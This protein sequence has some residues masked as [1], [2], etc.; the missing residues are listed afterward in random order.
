MSDIANENMI[1]EKL[2]PL[3]GKVAI[4]DDDYSEVASL[5][6]F[7]SKNSIPYNYYDGK[8]YNFPENKSPIQLIFI[9]LGINGAVDAKTL[10]ATLVSNV[11]AL[12]GDNNG[13]YCLAIWSNNYIQNKE[14]VDK[15]I[16]SLTNKPEF[17]FDMDKSLLDTCGL[18][19]S[20]TDSSLWESLKNNLVDGY[21]KR[22]LVG[23]MN[24][25]SNIYSSE[26]RNIIAVL[27]NDI[28]QD[29][30]EE[31]KLIRLINGL[32]KHEYE[33]RFDE[34]DKEYKL[35]LFIPIL[36]DYI[37]SKF[38]Q[39]LSQG[40][41]P[42]FINFNNDD[43][44][45]GINTT[46]LNTDLIIQEKLSL[47]YPR[48]V[49]IHGEKSQDELK[50]IFNNKSLQNISVAK[51]VMI[52]ITHLC[53]IAQRKEKYHN[54]VMGLLIEEN[55]DCDYKCKDYILDLHE[56]NFESKKYRFI[57]CCNHISTVLEDEIDLDKACFSISNNLY[58][59]IR[60]T[61][62]IYNSK[63]GL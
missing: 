10:A 43:D 46:N 25:L 28:S 14:V 35:N 39:K 51:E 7:L 4:L 15:S 21:S 8:M 18:D 52:D 26:L 33:K 12:I 50:S 56:I 22:S 17:Y 55:G 42:E 9:D 3:L 57:I 32:L 13:P 36:N 27:N 47:R 2:L 54:F 20:N 19:P 23:F 60:S 49:Y 6:R 38:N 41:L 48:N 31:K 24:I 5:M 59:H 40:G 44:T 34:I 11:N 58:N 37:S 62:A 61:I 45:S 63:I 1:E 29:V 16:E 30:S 53:S